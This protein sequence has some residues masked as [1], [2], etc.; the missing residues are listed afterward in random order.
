LCLLVIQSVAKDLR[1]SIEEGDSSFL[2]MTA[3]VLNK[4]IAT[5]SGTF[6]TKEP[7]N[8]LF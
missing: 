1:E 7:R 5:E 6:G 4:K 2:G 3:W 8:N